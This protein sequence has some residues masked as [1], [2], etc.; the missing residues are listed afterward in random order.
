MLSE[1]PTLFSNLS[2]LTKRSGRAK[3]YLVFYKSYCVQHLSFISFGPVMGASWLDIT[4]ISPYAGLTFNQVTR[5]SPQFSIDVWDAMISWSE[6]F[7]DEPTLWLATR[8]EEFKA[9]TCERHISTNLIR[10]L[11]KDANNVSTL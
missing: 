11:Q 4:S 5:K 10:T 2:F 9:I 3:T 6:L 8:L 7:G 1:A